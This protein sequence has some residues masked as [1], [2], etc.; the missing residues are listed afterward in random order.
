MQTASK[1]DASME[2]IPASEDK[3]T[4]EAKETA[5]ARIHMALTTF[6][7]AM[8]EG[9][10]T[11]WVDLNVTDDIQMRITGGVTN[12][13]S[14]CMGKQGL[15]MYYN[16]VLEN[17]WGLNSKVSWTPSCLDYSSNDEVV[18][19]LTERVT[20]PEGR[21]VLK[22]RSYIFKLRG[23]LIHI[24]TVDA[25]VDEDIQPCA[26]CLPEEYPIFTPAPFPPPT[27]S[28]PCSH[29]KWDSIRIK[30]KWCLLRCRVCDA[31]WRLPATAV[32]DTRCIPFITK[33]CADE[34]ECT[35]LHI[36]LRKQRLEERMAR[37]TDGD[38]EE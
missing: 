26:D 27:S 23:D 37:Q 14:G 38:R 32:S 7:T 5:V 35:L 12:V 30:R 21:E 22:H 20:F 29:N 11:D 17:V 15:C 13:N 8:N 10:F 28:C 34:E 6:F 33:G 9:W 25:P 19:N 2:P 3:V 24:I 31:Q 1:K 18:C 4:D 36:Y 16:R